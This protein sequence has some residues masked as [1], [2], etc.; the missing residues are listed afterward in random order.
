MSGQGVMIVGGVAG[1]GKSALVRSV[2]NEALIDVGSIHGESKFRSF[3]A[4]SWADVPH[5]FNLTELSLRLLV[6]FH[7]DNI[8]AK[9]T[10]AFA[11]M[12]GEDPIQG[13]CKFL[14][15]EYCLVVIDGIRSTYDLDLILAAFLSETIYGRLILITNESAVETHCA[16]SRVINASLN[17]KG[18]ESNASL[19]LF[20]KAKYCP[21]LVYT[22]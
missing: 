20:K 21:A 5:P 22:P 3:T 9:E 10:M 4:Y 17:V 6:D 13:C 2:Y 12:E 19:R 15:E 1:V 14:R 8:Q 11:M 7:S 16:D 18:L